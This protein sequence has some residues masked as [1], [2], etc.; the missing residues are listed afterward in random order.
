MVDSIELTQQTT[1]FDEPTQNSL[2]SISIRVFVLPPKDKK[3]AGHTTTTDDGP[4]DL[5]ADE[6]L[7]QK[8]PSPLASYLESSKGGKRCCVFLVNGQ[9]QDYLD[10]SFIYQDL[11]FKY[12]RHRMMIL[13]ECDTL[14]PEAIGKLMQGS[15]QGFY[16]GD[17][18]NAMLRQIVATLK[19]DPDLNRLEEE[20]EEQVSQLEAGDEKV[21]E[22]L[23]HLIEAHHDAA[24]Q[25]LEGLG[26]LGSSTIGENAGLGSRSRSAAVSLLDPT[27]GVAANY[28]VLT[29]PVKGSLRLH[30]NEERVVSVTSIPTNAWLARST[31]EVEPDPD[32]P[33]LRVVH[34]AQTDQGAIAMTFREPPDF[35][36]DLY[37]LRATIGVTVTFNGVSEPRRLAISAVIRPTKEAPEHQLQLEPSLLKVTSREPI[38]IR[39]GKSDVHVRF[40][41]DGQDDL[42]APPSATWT[43]RSSLRSD[44]PVP[45]M[46]FSEPRSGRFSLLI[47]PREEWAVGEWLEFEVVAIGPDGRT[48]SV[49]FI[50]EVLAEE[51]RQGPNAPEPR[52][53]EQELRVGS[54]RRP[55]Y[56]LMYIDRSKYDA[57]ECWAGLNWTDKD[58]G[59]FAA[60]TQRTPLRLII[61]TDMDE[62]EAYKRFLTKKGRVESEVE[63]RMNKYTSHVAF[64]LYQMYQ[65]YA[66]HADKQSDTADEA[67]RDEIKRVANTLLKLMEVSR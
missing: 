13:I 62:L 37:P 65:A 22:T 32:H 59:C 7:E 12:L 23:N 57:I 8:R 63:R 50:A 21:K 46:T 53:L 5:D 31:F 26:G 9:R 33:E 10:N 18:W 24:S 66:D 39:K 28:P 52:L 25:L 55:P 30:P 49:A 2:G 16:R 64:H 3:N 4:A 34:H 42:L 43:L 14:S 11:G 41:W 36:Q 15:R 19:D 35:D 56:E 58:P 40:R 54:T 17:V 48:L 45:S 44:R 60:P 29:T 1:L 67:R 6:A 61:N 20:A 38:K 51:A 27:A 47:S